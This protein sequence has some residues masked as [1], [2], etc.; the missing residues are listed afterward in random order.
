MKKIFLSKIILLITILSFLLTG[1]TPVNQKKV[2]PSLEWQHSRYG[3]KVGFAGLYV[4]EPNKDGQTQI[5]AT[6]AGKNFLSSY[7]YVREYERSGVYK[8]VW[9]SPVYPISMV[10]LVRIDVTKDGVKDYIAALQDGT[11]YIYDGGNFKQI[12]TFHV[13]TLN[14]LGDIAVADTDHD[15]VIELVAT[16]TIGLYV[17][18]IQTGMQLWSTAN[19][20]GGGQSLVVGNVDNDSA[21]EIIAST[22]PG[23]GY[24]TDGATHTI[25]WESPTGF[26][27]IYQVGDLDGDGVDE[28]IG[29]PIWQ[30]ISVFNAVNHTLKNEIA[31]AYDVGA[32]LIQ[33]VSGD[34][35]PEIIYGNGQW[36]DIHAID[37]VSNIELW[38]IRDPGHGVTA[39]A[40]GDTDADGQPEVLWGSNSNSGYGN[41][42]IGNPQSQSIK[43][44]GTDLGG[45]LSAQDVGDIDGDGK[46]EI[47]MASF[48][49]NDHFSPAVLSCFDAKTH[50]LKW[51]TALEVGSVTGIRAL[52]IAD[53]D[54]D[55]GNEIVLTSVSVN[56]GQLFI[57]DGK[58]H[59]L[60]AKTA[61][62]NGN[63]FTTVSVADIDGDG[64]NE[65]VGGLGAITGDA[66]YIVVFDGRSLQ[67]KWKYDTFSYVY[68]GVFDLKLA[69]LNGNGISDIVASIPD[70]NLV[71]AYDGITHNT[72]WQINTKA[73]ALAVAN[74]NSTSAKEILLGRADGK[75]DVYSSGNF[76][77]QQTIT[78]PATKPVY[79]L[80]LED[81]DQDG[82]MD[83]LMASGD[84]V[85]QLDP[86]NFETPLWHLGY[87][88]ENL[89][90]HN[91]LV[92]KDINKDGK[93]K[94]LLG[95]DEA[96]YQFGL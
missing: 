24:V 86:T 53:I 44:T 34:A 40:W 63:F 1:C 88:S 74:I 75:I 59:S 26:G 54:N 96:L 38:S 52:K 2:A 7:W 37:P 32:I 77:F 64:S 35:L 62:Y 66:V 47:V 73:Y 48:D 8:E 6:A 57:Y 76:S 55:G 3:D 85:Y 14:Q 49:S 23:K 43:W 72:L 29:S 70:N 41:F 50:T 92:V 58:T 16:D 12:K 22:Y 46:N 94:L 19:Y 69:D 28:I 42:F 95:S 67:E 27:N 89:G 4:T 91:Q 33:N 79:G 65:I 39:L 51:Q 83:W 25:E 31:T 71:I 10:R 15:G 87:L 78:T 18:S 60:K 82:K 20:E 5:V 56:A 61:A 21:L 81:L 93:L 17:Y 84:I 36:G 80:H 90:W 11:V 68:E 30:N 9:H 45:P 13:T